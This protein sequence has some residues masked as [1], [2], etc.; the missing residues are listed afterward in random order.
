MLLNCTIL[1]QMFK[2]CC[3][4]KKLLLEIHAAQI[5]QFECLRQIDIYSIL[6]FFTIFPNQEVTGALKWAT[7]QT[8]FQKIVK[9]NAS[10]V[11]S[12]FLVSKIDR[13]TYR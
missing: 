9:F 6:R 7:W 5:V 12:C 10:R 11:D 4:L 13:Y 8:Y 2:L 3:T 1:F